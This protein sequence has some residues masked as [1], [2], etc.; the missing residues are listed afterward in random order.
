M[1]DEAPVKSVKLP[2]IERLVVVYPE[3]YQLR[4]ENVQTT[5]EDRLFG[6]KGG[7]EECRHGYPLMPLTFVM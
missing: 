7:D 6:D 4:S 5:A 1:E 3:G 2:M